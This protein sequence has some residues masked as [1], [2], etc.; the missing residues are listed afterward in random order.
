MPE[1][2]L[3]SWMPPWLHATELERFEIAGAERWLCLRPRKGSWDALEQGLRKA[4]EVLRGM[5][6]AQIVGAIDRVAEQWCDRGF[7]VRQQAL[8]RVVAA[9]GFSAE[10]VERSFDVELRNYRADSLWRSLRR[11][12]GDPTVLDTFTHDRSLAGRARAIG[13]GITLAIFTGNVPGLPALS[14]VRA[15]LV[16]S[17]VLAKVASGE[18]TFAAAFAR[19]LADEDARLSDALAITYWD[20]DDRATL[21]AALAHS[22]AVI[23]YGGGTAVRAVRQAIPDARRYVE[24][25]HKIS[26][27]LVSRGYR[28][29]LGDAELARRIA[30]DVSTFNQH[31]CIAPQSYLVE[32][33]AGEAQGLLDRVAEAL[34]SY[35]RE[36]PLGELPQQDAAELQ[37]RRAAHAWSAAAE[38]ESG[39]FRRAP[40]LDW[41]VSLG[42]ELAS[43][44]GGGNR[45]LRLVPTASLQE[46]VERLR[47]YGE[48]LQ[49]V[50]LGAQG[51][52]LETTAERLALLGA[53]RICEPG[54]MAEPSLMWRHDG[55]MCIADLVRWCDVEMHAQLD[56]PRPA[57]PAVG[58]H[59]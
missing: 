3:I 24:H 57:A 12:L 36:C 35:A 21:D 30:V 54:R 37:L 51:D 29:E 4:A 1:P 47:P 33:D 28:Q 18:P 8:E 49:N 52:E 27:G 26:V 14:L 58:I 46:A 31:A 2:T 11:E 40:G 38:G 53:S 43:D 5:R 34:A 32:A 23:A 22:D 39:D 42:S 15:L 25:G 48:H 44:A 9:T 59:R 56:G 10:A 41:T 17:A 50:A 6:L 20:R 55:R 7:A 16:K 45:F 19:T 13:P